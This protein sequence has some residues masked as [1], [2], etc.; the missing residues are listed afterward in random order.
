[1]NNIANRVSKIDGVKTACS[2]G[3]R[4]LQSQPGTVNHVGSSEAE[5]H[6]RR[7]SNILYTTEPR[8]AL[9]GGGGGGGGRG[10]RASVRPA[11]RSRHL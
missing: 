7:G 11:F 8:I 10:G 2:R 6:R 3:E 9:G 5:Y 4:A 1:M